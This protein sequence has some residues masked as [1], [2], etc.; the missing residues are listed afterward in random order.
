MNSQ[1]EFDTSVNAIICECVTALKLDEQLCGMLPSGVVAITFDEELLEKIDLDSPQ[2]R[3]DAQIELRLFVIKVRRF[4]NVKN[5]DVKD[6]LKLVRE[7]LIWENSA[8]PICDIEPELRTGKIVY[9]GRGGTGIPI[10]V[11]KFK[12]HFAPAKDAGFTRESSTNLMFA[13][14][15]LAEHL[16]P[17][18]GGSFE[19][20]ID[21]HSFG[22][23]NIDRGILKHLGNIV[24]KY[25]PGR[26]RKC[27]I[28]RPPMIVSGLWR[29]L[30]PLVPQRWMEILVFHKE[31]TKVGSIIGT[32]Q[33]PT[34]FGGE[35][36]VNDSKW[37]DV[38]ACAIINKSELTLSDCVSNS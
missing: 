4:I 9:A 34:V 26:I 16:S 21:L 1:T 19:L 30:R 31:A 8:K 25:F 24:S 17:E 10:F 7:W 29:L 22:F 38:S 13:I 28:V 15:G 5:L 36:E 12:L 3:D 2:L 18:T 11:L 35:L 37:S 32:S 33:F 27:H 20:V 6:T 14:F 23:G